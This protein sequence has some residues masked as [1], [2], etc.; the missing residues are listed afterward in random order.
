MIENDRRAPAGWYASDGAFV[1]ETLLR[2]VDDAIARFEG[3]LAEA[4]TSALARAGASPLVEQVLWHF[5]LGCGAGLRRGKRLRPRLVFAVAFE[6]G[7]DYRQALDAAVAI[8][9][10]HN[11]SLVH[12]DIEDGDAL[13]HGRETVWARYGLPHGI[14]C[15]DSMC[16]IT[17]LALLRNSGGIDTGR[18]AAM[19]AALHAANLAMCAGQAYD[20]SFERALQVTPSAYAAMIEGKT[21]VL[22]GAACELG[23]LAA[24]ACPERARAYG[25][26]GRA[27]GRA[28]Q[29]HDDMLGTWASAAQTGK[30]AR[31]DIGR[32]KWT[33]PVVWALAGPQSAARDA[34]ARRYR[35]AAPLGPSDV[36]AVVNAL[37]ALSARRA[38]EDAFSTEIDAAARIATEHGLDREGIV[39][40]QLQECV[41]APVDASSKPSSAGRR[42][43]ST[44]DATSA[45]TTP[46]RMPSST[47]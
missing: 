38:A 27:Y 14:N 40:A 3:D 7:G 20:L 22:F 19:A 23:A 18:V 8:E 37:D 11:Y 46:V 2:T 39:A 34:I 24:G 42:R 15:G 21:A 16:A 30:A 10:L 36:D 9:C 31:A 41:P 26:I 28:F 35:A 25:D 44:I 47:G 43:R 1:P 32:R 17:Y 45:S 13:R 5:G 12:D 29:I 33:Y 6:E 4:V